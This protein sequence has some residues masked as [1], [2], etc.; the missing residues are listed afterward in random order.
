V[1]DHERVDPTPPGSGQAS[2]AEP[3]DSLIRRICAGETACFEVLMRRHNERIYRTVRAVLGDDADVEDVMQQAYVSAYQHLDRFEGRARFSTW[4][5]RIAINEAYA[6]LRKR[7]RTEPAPWEDEHAMADEPEAAGPSPEQIAARQ[8]MQGLLERAVDTLSMPNRTVFVLR[9]IEGLFG[10]GGQD[11]PASRQRSAAAVAGRAGRRRGQGR[12]PV[13]S[14][15]L[16]RRRRT[17]DVPHRPLI[18][19][20]VGGSASRDCTCLPLHGTPTR[21]GPTVR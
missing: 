8:E 7:H 10:G 2:A 14:P 4:M 17:C 12:L 13:L 21:A 16:R 15:A 20:G 6:R 18:A 19:G 5:T 3:D 1:T 9:S 11:A